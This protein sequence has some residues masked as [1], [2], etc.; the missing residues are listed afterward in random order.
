[1]SST[2]GTPSAVASE[3]LV[4]A[5]PSSGG[6]KDVGG[7]SLFMFPWVYRRVKVQAMINS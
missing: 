7:E 5:F 2:V 6:A 4:V 1:M 3:E